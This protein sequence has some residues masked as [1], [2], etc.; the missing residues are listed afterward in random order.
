MANDESRSEALDLV[1]RGAHGYI[2]KPP[3]V[4]RIWCRRGRCCAA[5]NW[6]SKPSGAASP[7]SNLKNRSCLLTFMPS[8]PD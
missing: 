6:Q 2:R 3:V 1:E 4:R 7:F 5:M 8:K